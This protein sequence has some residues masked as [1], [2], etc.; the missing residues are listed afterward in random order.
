LQEGDGDG[1]DDD[2]NND[3]NNNNNNNNADSLFNEISCL[4]GK[5]GSGAIQPHFFLTSA[6]DV[7]FT[8]R[9]V[10]PW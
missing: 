3:N 1:D 2:N 4:E 5:L 10:I 8:Q 7:N 9:P 6:L